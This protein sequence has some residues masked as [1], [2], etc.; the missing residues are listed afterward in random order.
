MKTINVTVTKPKLVIEYD[1][2]CESPRTWSNIGYFLTFERN[3]KSPD[4]NKDF[5]WI[6]ELATDENVK[7]VADHIQ[8][9][10]KNW[11]SKEYGKIVYI[12]AV[13]RFEHGVVQYK[14]GDLSGWDYSTCGFYIVT[15]KSQ[16]ELGTPDD[17]IE[18]VIQDELDC[19]N[20]W[21]N[22]EVFLF[23]LYNNDGEVKDSCSGF[24]S[25]ED[26][27]EYLPEEWANEDLSQ[28]LKN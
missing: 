16:Q 14:L 22:G 3:Y 15:D 27:K 8:E 26:I 28:Y 13:T 20:K 7:C 24:Y 2:D 19:Y 21:R 23:V 4:D 6:K 5:K 18:Y 17:K 12:E 25:L 9:I 10:E 11:D 1:G